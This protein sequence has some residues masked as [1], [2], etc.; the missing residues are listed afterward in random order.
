MIW[1][2][3]VIARAICTQTL[4]RKC[5]VLVDNCSWTGYECDVLAVTGAL[6]IIDV[7]IKISRAD[8]KADAAKDKWWE[9]YV[10]QHDEHTCIPAPR[11]WPRRVWKHYFAM[12]AEIW[13]PDLLEHL[14]SPASGVIVM[15]EQQH[16]N[17]AARVVATV[18]RRAVPNR[19]AYQ[20]GAAEVADIAR[21]AT[22]RLWDA[23]AII[24][25]LKE[26][27]QQQMHFYSSQPRR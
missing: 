14:P 18:V 5:L 16:G 9:R 8:L 15:R 2:E 12:P 27:F 24:D 21:L 3:A 26:D 4:N 1:S 11:R 7:E 6:K 22:L 17:G 10:R 20:L 23:Y 13:K 25:R 19:N